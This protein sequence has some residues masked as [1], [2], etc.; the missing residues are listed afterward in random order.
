LRG[1][2]SVSDVSLAGIGHA[3]DGNA[4]GRIL[5]I[6]TVSASRRTPLTIYKQVVL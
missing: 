2:D 4:S 3:G 6:E 1:L 5:N